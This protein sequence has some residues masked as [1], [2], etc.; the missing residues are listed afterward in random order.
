[1]WGGHCPVLPAVCLP[2]VSRPRFPGQS[3][4]RIPTM[5]S[6]PAALGL[7]SRS[8]QMLLAMS[9]SLQSKPI[10]PLSPSHGPAEGHVHHSARGPMG[11]GALPPVTY[12]CLT[13][14]PLDCGSD[15]WGSFR[16]HDRAGNG[17]LR[18]Q[19]TAGQQAGGGPAL[20][21]CTDLPLSFL[22]FGPNSS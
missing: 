14:A 2:A 4:P 6:I 11:N 19:E 1:M 13:R 3:C 12:L 16:H 9:P 15:K 8:F 21:A 17:P 5:G 18:G 22:A 10:H 7:A 20:G